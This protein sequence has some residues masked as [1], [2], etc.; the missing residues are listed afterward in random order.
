MVELC[1][2][3][4][5]HMPEVKTHI[6]LTCQICGKQGL[7]PM[8]PSKARGRRVVVCENEEILHIKSNGRH[9]LVHVHNDEI[10]QNLNLN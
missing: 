5:K 7:I 6:A 2:H 1:G 4:L 3:F 8:M 10:P 9:Y